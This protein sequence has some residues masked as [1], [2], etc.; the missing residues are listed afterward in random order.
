[1]AAANNYAFPGQQ[2]GIFVIGDANN[3]WVPTR[4]IWNEQTYHITNVN[5]DDTIPAHEQNS[6]QIYNSYRTNQLPGLGR[7]AAPDLTA[8]YVRV[9]TQGT[10]TAY[11]VRLGNGGSTF[12]P[13]GVNVAFYN[14]DPRNGGV[15]LGLATSTQ[16]LDPGTYEDLILTADGTAGDLWVQAD[17]DGNGVGHINECD[18]TNNLYHPDLGTPP[19]QAGGVQGTVRDLEFPNGLV[20][21]WKGEGNALDSSGYANNGTLQGGV[22]FSAAEF[23]EGFQ[24][25]DS[26]SE[27]ISVPDSPSLDVNTVTLSAW[28]DINSLPS[29]TADWVIVTKGIQGYQ[30][31]N[32]GLYIHRLS[33]DAMELLFEYQDGTNYKVISD[34]SGLTTGRFYHVAVTADG[35]NVRFYLNGTLVS[36]A[37]Q[38]TALAV[39]DLPLQIGSSQPD[40]ANYFDGVIDD[41]QIYDRA[42][43]PAEIEA[44]GQ[45]PAPP[46]GWTVYLDQNQNG[47]RD[48]GERFTVTDGLGNYSFN[49]LAPGTY[50]IAVEGQPGWE[51]TAPVDGAQSVPLA[52]GQTVFGI[53]VGAQPVPPVNRPPHFTSAAPSNATVG[54]QLV[55]QASAFDPDNDPLTF[56]LP[57]H[58]TGMVV[59]GTTGLVTWTPDSSEVGAQTAILRVQ[60][61][62][63]GVDLQ[64]FTI[65]VVQSQ[66]LSGI[67]GTVYNDL[68]GDGVRDLLGTNSPPIPLLN[69][70]GTADIYLA[71]MPNGST[72]SGTDSAPGQSP[73]LVPNLALTGGEALM[74]SVPVGAVNDSISNTST[75][76]GNGSFTNHTATAQNGIS[77]IVAPAGALIGVFLGPDQPD[78]T[79]P[80]SSL[81]FSSAGNVNGGIDYATLSPELQQVFFIGD[82]RTSTG[83]IQQIV[84]PQGA[85]RL[86]LGVMASG[87]TSTNFGSF[88]VAV[89]PYDPASAPGLLSPV[90]LPTSIP[91]SAYSLAYYEPDNAVLAD[92][93][94]GIQEIKPDGTVL[95]FFQGLSQSE[96]YIASARWDNLGGFEPGDVFLLDSPTGQLIR[97]TDGGRTVLNPWLNFG[98]SGGVEDAGLAFDSAGLFG[99]DLIAL[100]GGDVWQIDANDNAT[101]LSQINITGHQNLEGLAVLPNDPNRYGPLAGCVIVGQDD[102]TASYGLGP[103][104]VGLWAIDA[105]GKATFYDLGLSA[106]DQGGGS[107]GIDAIGVVQPNTN[108]FADSISAPSLQEAPAS[109][110][111]TMAGDIFVV[112][113]GAGSFGIFRV[114]WNGQS[115]QA[116]LF[117]QLQYQPN[118]SLLFAPTGVTPLPQKVIEPS[119]AGWTAYLDLNHDGKLDSGEPTSIT[120]NLGHYSFSNL[121]PGTYTVAETLQPAWQ[122]TQPTGGTYTVTLQ[123]GQIATSLDFGNTALGAPSNQTPTISSAP[124]T[125]VALGQ[126]YR[127]A[128]QAGDPDSDPLT[129]SLT[130]A[131]AGMTIDT[132]GLITWTPTTAQF[133]ANSVVVHVDDGN[134]GTVDQSF[135]VNVVAQQS[136]HLPLITSAPPLAAT[137]GSLYSYNATGKDPD[138]TPLLW[139]LDTAPAGMTIDPVHGGILWTPTLGELGSQHV[140]LRLTNGEGLWVKQSFKV[141]VQ[142]I[143]VPPVI[144]SDPSTQTGVGQAYTY[145]VQASDADGD[146]LT[147]SLTAAPV[148]MTI[149]P[150][151]GFVQWTPTAAQVGIQSASI[152]VSDGRGG[153]AGQSWN[154]VVAGTA[155]LLPPTI[156]SLPSGAATVGQPYA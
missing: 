12:V 137:A 101:L 91:M 145:A 115:L 131:P 88:A 24:F 48:L 72:A 63:G 75:P 66:P 120:D 85:T 114:F 156:T 11:T 43:S 135:T 64:E 86:Y 153:F 133:G 7:F 15:L 3:T 100:N 83:D 67:R 84:V 10:Q 1:V 28:V 35:T 98:P 50:Q 16:R 129:F 110:L 76:D 23:G 150:T 148:G 147:Y 122:E 2:T 59:D 44:L 123:A 81:D 46:Q 94:G 70:P 79:A 89:Q 155:V 121:P 45:P 25:H 117:S 71:G 9:A 90:I 125:S 139:S 65:S 97:I 93:G 113:E 31:E 77:D 53:D 29:P 74:V 138:N 17:D 152:L 78:G 40:F 99:G 136:N 105:Q 14:G 68:N 54:Q 151:T 146:P 132:N 47:H 32:Y 27:L 51:F 19:F 6:W 140:V 62:R 26:S 33:T 39:N 58:P 119:L 34:G 108:L 13:A 154:V 56:D 142:A 57:V 112:S 61:N 21:W 107:A 42:L 128:V 111:Q 95:P 102:A 127:Y 104:H 109:Q 37:P 80:P 73:F 134:G 87:A 49:N 92:V 5:D 4:Q 130:T 30:S 141:T 149:D 143:N 38:V 124:R 60:D 118:E 82:G 103:E 55:Y 52:N 8:S 144:T 22:T 41:L 126:T 116:Q 18:E 20:A 36:T 106:Y 96:T 69:V